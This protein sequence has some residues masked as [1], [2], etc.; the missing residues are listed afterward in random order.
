MLCRTGKL[1]EEDEGGEGVN[2]SW[3]GGMV[4]LCV[5][6]RRV[7]CTLYWRASYLFSSSFSVR[8]TCAGLWSRP[9]PYARGNDTKMGRQ[10]GGGGGGRLRAEGLLSSYC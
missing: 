9:F 8:R 5:G 1:D 7:C 4:C 3:R 2:K 6:S 10:M